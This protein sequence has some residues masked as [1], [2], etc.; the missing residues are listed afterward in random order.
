M[1]LYDSNIPNYII[2]KCSSALNAVHYWCLKQ[3]NENFA[4]L[5]HYTTKHKLRDVCVFAWFSLSLGLEA[6]TRT[7][8]KQRQRIEL[9]QI[10]SILAMCYFSNQYYKQ[11]KKL[12][13]L[14]VQYHHDKF[15]TLLFCGNTTEENL[16]LS[17]VL[18]HF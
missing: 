18:Y 12:K 13:N 9:F 4:L 5:A 7:H 15:V 11:T 17:S 10:W 6:T 8:K 14:I 16:Y 3:C 1:C 2:S